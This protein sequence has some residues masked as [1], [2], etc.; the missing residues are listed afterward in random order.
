[1]WEAIYA[2]FQAPAPAL[3]PVLIPWIAAFIA[4]N[5][6]VM[7]GVWA[8]LKYIAKLTPWAE[9]DKILQII[10][11][12][13]TAVKDAVKPKME[14]KTVPKRCGKCGEYL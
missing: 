1:M 12:G 11:G 9:D 13:F 5:I 6:I 7:T 8:L 10:T 3:D 14:E 4:G 2:F